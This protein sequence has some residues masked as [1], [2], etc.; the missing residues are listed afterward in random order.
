[1]VCL[2]RIAL[3]VRPPL[4]LAI[5][6]CYNALLLRRSYHYQSHPR[7]HFRNVKL[8]PTTKRI[9]SST[10]ALPHPNLSSKSI[11]KTLNDCTRH[12][13][14]ISRH[15]LLLLT[16]IYLFFQLGNAAGSSDC[17]F[18]DGCSS[19]LSPCVP[20]EKRTS[21]EHSG[22]CNLWSPPNNAIDVC[23]TSDLCF[24]KEATDAR[25]TVLRNGCTD[26]S[27]TDS[28]C[29]TYCKTVV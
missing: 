8:L 9:N 4:S 23:T 15:H 12:S 29:T 24:W 26:S 25:T 5:D 17:F 28:I 2:N 6:M 27:L 19:K 18:L 16:R 3:Q 11:R 21:G 22:F 20:A 13:L 7:E 14:P 1:M 10:V